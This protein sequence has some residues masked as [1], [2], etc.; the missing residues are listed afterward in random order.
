[1]KVSF[2]VPAYNEAAR[3]KACLLAIQGELTR[4][5]CNAE[6]IVVNNAST[7]DTKAIALGISSVR[8]VDEPRK[9]LVMARQAGFE[10]ATGDLIA[11]I[12]ADVVLPKG[13]LKTVLK[14]FDKNKKLVVLSG[15]FIYHDLSVVK[16][17][18]VKVFYFFAF[19]LYLINRFML[20]VGSMV[21]GGNFVLRRDAL[22]KV[23]GYDTSITFYGEDTDVAK[24]LSKVGAVKWTFTLP[25][26]TSGRRL[27]GEGIVVTSMRYT[28][29]Y[30]WVTFFG[31]PF[32]YR[33]KD[34]RPE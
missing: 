10:A 3:I 7:D 15:P 22:Q 18:M 34:I 27:K 21:Q 19:L 25:V 31:K 26:Y 12:D 16:R 23:G 14:E 1:M 4:T 29:N 20:R 2:V 9:G 8:V 5:P 24:R 33:Y 32:T 13:W 6:I 11:N 17:A 30:F 28:I